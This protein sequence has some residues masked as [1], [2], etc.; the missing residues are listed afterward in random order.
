[1]GSKVKG[2]GVIDKWAVIGKVKGYGVQGEGIW[3]RIPRSRR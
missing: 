2:Y 1:M 3:G